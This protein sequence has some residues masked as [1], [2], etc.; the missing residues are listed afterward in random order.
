MKILV[1]GMTGRMCG[2]E[3]HKDPAKLLYGRMQAIMYADEMDA[4][5]HDVHQYLPSWDS[6]LSSFDRI[7]LGVAPLSSLSANNFIEM[8]RILRLY[9]EKVTL[10]VE[11][12]S[13]EN[14]TRDWIGK[15]ADGGWRKHLKWKGYSESSG[16]D[17][18]RSGLLTVVAGARCPYRVVA[19]MFPWGDHDALMGPNYDVDALD[20]SPLIALPDMAD[21][22]WRQ[23]LENTLSTPKLRQWVLGA[24]S[25]QERWV[26]K[27]GFTWPV[28]SFGHRSSGQTRLPERELVQT[29]AD[30]W[31]VLCPPYK[32]SGTG[33]WRNRYNWSAHVGSILYCG[34]SD[35]N[36][37]MA[38]YMYTGSEIEGMTDQQ[39]Q[40][41]A[42]AQQEWFKSNIWTRGQFQDS[43]A[44]ILA[45]ARS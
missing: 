18:V 23:L 29:Y 32:K 34:P 37:M 26:Q 8:G 3:R 11:D 21:V 39:L 30:N 2:N 24:L 40:S 44:S 1:T 28:K 7:W 14:L 12:W 15:L 31:G 45:R 4:M 25:D 36:E 42:R 17:E 6:D 43:L 38:E 9:P 10:F 13:V 16:T 33:W 27:Q 22:A 35:G 20:V 19:S 41:V 5:G